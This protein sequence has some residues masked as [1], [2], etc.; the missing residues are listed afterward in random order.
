MTTRAQAMGALAGVDPPPVAFL[1]G[2]RHFLSQRRMP[3][4]SRPRILV[5]WPR[6]EGQSASVWLRSVHGV[7]DRTLLVPACV[8]R[9]REAV[10]GLVAEYRERQPCGA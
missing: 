4:G 8:A 2:W 1:N 7:P 5:V 10:E 9:V 6:V 3:D